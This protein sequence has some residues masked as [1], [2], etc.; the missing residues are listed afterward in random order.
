MDGRIRLSAKRGMIFK[1]MTIEK[2][3]KKYFRHKI[4]KIFFL[5]HFLLV[6]ALKM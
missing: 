4:N 2:G 5:T 1:W 3:V 6:F